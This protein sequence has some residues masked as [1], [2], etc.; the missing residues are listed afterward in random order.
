M[1]KKKRNSKAGFTLVEVA[2][3]MVII[4]LLIGGILKGQEM[5][6]NAKIKRVMKQMDELRAAVTSYQDRYGGLL[7]GDDNAAVARGWAGVVNGNGNG[8]IL[9]AE[10]PDMFMHLA[11]ANLLSGTYTTA[12]TSFPRNPFG[13]QYSV[14]YQAVGTRTTHWFITTSIPGDIAVVL[15]TSYDDG[16]FNTGTIRAVA[17]YNP[18]AN[19]DLFIE[20]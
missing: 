9:L 19:A 11:A 2:I 5:I 15:D 7:P 6:K 3:V 8:Q 12:A 4:G 20:F 17:A 16:V 1:F 14:Q 10:A 18:N 13:G